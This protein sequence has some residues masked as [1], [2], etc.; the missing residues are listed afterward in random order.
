[1]R[2]LS[3]E[4]DPKLQSIFDHMP[5]CWGCKNKDSIFMYANKTYASIV[6]I[7]PSKHLD[8]I[9]ELLQLT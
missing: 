8:V 7:D 9:D 2:N 1:M 3:S 5:G 4:V 6:G